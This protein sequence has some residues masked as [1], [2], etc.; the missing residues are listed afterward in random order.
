M[1]IPLDTFWHW[2]Y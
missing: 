2:E 1:Q